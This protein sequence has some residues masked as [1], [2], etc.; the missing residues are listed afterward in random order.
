MT[1]LDAAAAGDLAALNAAIKSGADVEARSESGE[2][3]LHLASGRGDL[4]VVRAL[5][6]AG[7]DPNPSSLRRRAEPAG[8]SSFAPGAVTVADL[9]SG[10]APR[11][12]RD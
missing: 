11:P 1:L 5:L 12:W 9:S 4:E 7:A 10:E 2:T 8:P 3:A 6:N